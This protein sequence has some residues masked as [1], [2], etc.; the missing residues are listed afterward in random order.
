MEKAFVPAID[1]E[2]FKEANEYTETT[3]SVVTESSQMFELLSSLNDH[4]DDL[5][6][7]A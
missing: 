3:L 7:H 5:Y 4:S 2:S 1:N 6:A